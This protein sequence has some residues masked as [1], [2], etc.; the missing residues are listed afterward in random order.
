MLGA[1]K[2]AVPLWWIAFVEWE[3][4]MIDTLY[5]IAVDTPKYH[6]RGTLA[7]KSAEG[8]IVAKLQV[9]D[10]D[11]MEFT[12]TCSDKEFDFEGERDLPSLGYVAFKAHGSVWGNS[13]TATCETDAGKIEI[14]GTELSASAG[15]ARSSHGYIM[16]ASTGDTC[17]DGMMYSGLYADGG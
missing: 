12:G 4:T 7:L 8:S 13:V 17:D 10:L 2:W 3:K 6:R 1:K 11:M 15:G 5:D 9:S 16:T 14:F